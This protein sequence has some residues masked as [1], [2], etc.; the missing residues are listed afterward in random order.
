MARIMPELEFR[1]F[2]SHRSCEIMPNTT[3]LATLPAAAIHIHMHTQIRSQP[4]PTIDRAT[5]KL[6]S[7]AATQLQTLSPSAPRRERQVARQH[8]G[9]SGRSS[10]GR[11]LSL[12][13][14]TSI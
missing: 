10:G 3:R 7:C 4:Q 9:A 13:T 8:H 2:H 1:S 12:A 11:R 6:Y 14:L 5:G